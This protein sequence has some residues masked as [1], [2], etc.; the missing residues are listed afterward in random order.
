MLIVLTGK[1]GVQALVGRADHFEMP[2]KTKEFG[3]T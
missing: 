2:P 1:M 3:R